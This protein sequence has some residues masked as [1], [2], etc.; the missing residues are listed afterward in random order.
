MNSLLLLLQP[1]QQKQ[2]NSLKSSRVKL[3]S[4]SVALRQSTLIRETFGEESFM[5]KGTPCGTLCKWDAEAS[6]EQSEE[7]NTIVAMHFPMKCYMYC[8]HRKMVDSL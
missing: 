4:W 3:H 1:L 2:E 5:W 7:L 8:H 6:M